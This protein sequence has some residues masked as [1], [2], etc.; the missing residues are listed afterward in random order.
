MP[1]APLPIAFPAHGLYLVTPD[2]DD[3]STLLE[4]VA[5][6][7]PHAACLQYR[8]KRALDP[9]QRLLE[10]HSLRVLC[11]EAGVCFIVNDDPLLARQVEA[12]GVHLG[13]GDGEVA[14]ARRLLG[15]ARCI[16]VTCHDQ[17]PLAR[18]A[19]AEGADYVAF[20]AMF[21]STTKPDAPRA[22]PQLFMRAAALGVPKVAIGGITPDNAGQAMAAGADLAAVIAGVFDA[23]DP[24][25]AARACAAAIHAAR[26][27]RSLHARP[28]D[29]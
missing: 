17:W 23:P 6:L 21:P 28:H 7:L 12:D 13:Q 1:P 20:G 14:A 24:L 4:R 16:G 11:A 22:T 3:S 15:D 27:A 25:A 18:Q 29:R 8:N 9:T 2:S 5:P 26:T 19:V 10:A